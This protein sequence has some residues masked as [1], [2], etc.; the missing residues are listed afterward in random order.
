[1]KKKILIAI[2]T[3][4][5]GGV[6]V[7]LIR[8]IN[9]L[10]KNKDLTINLLMLKKIGIYLKDIPKN[11][12]VLEV[13]Y[14]NNMYNYN[15]HIGD[16]KKYK[17]IINKIKYLVIRL[18]L[19]NYVNKNNWEAYYKMILAYTKD[20]DGEY[21]LAIDW[22]GYG[23]FITT[24]IADKV[25]AKRKAMWLHDEKNDWLDKISYW[26]DSF[27]KIFCVGVSVM[28][29]AIKNKPE[30]KKK[31]E[32]FYNMTDYE[33][34]RKKA[35]DK[36]DIIFDKNVTNIV[37]VGRLEWQKAYDVAIETAS[38]L[39]Q[40]NFKF[41][42]YVIGGGTKEQELKDLVKQKNLEDVFI[43]LGVIA[44]PFPLVK[45]ADLYVLSSRHEGYCLATLEA[46]ILN[47]VIIATDIESNREQIKN[48]ENGFLCPLKPKAFADK[49]IEV[50]KDENI[51][52][53][54]LKNLQKENFDYRVEFTKLY[55]LMG[56]KK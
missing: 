16:F 19:R 36:T 15:N 4:N 54:V 2:P 38:L 33:N 13:E 28:N 31:Y 25:T 14:T 29:N 46:K 6:E 44:N 26:Q 56:V 45:K 34:V 51:K 1:M 21:D 27:D 11:V 7:S 32:V 39:K 23:H 50:A 24:V 9:E 52:K 22:H 12:N 20:V 40:A 30:L 43:F 17:G 10:A 55:K 3:L 5:S 8:F 18:K 48:G 49:I 53:Q 37:T 47:K 35:E 41:K 42:W